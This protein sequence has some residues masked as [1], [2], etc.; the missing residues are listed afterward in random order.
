MKKIYAFLT[1]VFACITLSVYAQPQANQQGPRPQGPREDRRT[2]VI[3]DNDLCGDAD[4]LFA[5]AH[6]L[7]CTFFFFSIESSNL[8][9]F[10]FYFNGF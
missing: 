2:K 1:V 8:Q 9:I 10:I 3:I 5:L 6:Q 7:L 4:G